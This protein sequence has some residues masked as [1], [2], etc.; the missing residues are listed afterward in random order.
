MKLSTEYLPNFALR[1]FLSFLMTSTYFFEE[2]SLLITCFYFAFFV[3]ISVASYSKTTHTKS[4]LSQ[5]A[6][7]I[8]ISIL[9]VLTFLPSSII[10][11]GIYSKKDL[12]FSIIA[13]IYFFFLVKDIL[14]LS[15][16]QSL[17]IRDYKEEKGTFRIYFLSFLMVSLIYLWAFYPGI[18]VPDSINQW[19]QIHSSM[20]WNDWH[21]I[22]HTFLIKVT[23]LIGNKPVTF[24]LFQIVCYSL[25]MAYAMDFIKDYI[26]KS[27]NIFVLCFFLVFPLLPLSSIQIIKDS[28]FTIA[29]VLLTICLLKIVGSQGEWLSSLSHRCTLSLSFLGVIFFRHN[30]WPVFIVF[31]LICLLFLRKGYFRLY[32]TAFICALFYLVI[33]GPIYNHYEVIR[34]DS[35]ES[36]GMLIQISGEIISSDGD[37]NEKEATYYYS[38]MSKENWKALYKPRDVD[39][40]KFKSRFQKKI[41][42][43]D[44]QTFILTTLS[45]AKK[46]PGLA[47]KAYIQQTEVL[48]HTNMPSENL[49]PMFRTQLKGKA[50]P[51]YFLSQ[52]QM[53]K[54][55]PDYRGLFLT[56]SR[57][58]SKTLENFFVSLFDRIFNSSIRYLFMPAVFLIIFLLSSG[59]L[60]LKGYGLYTLAFL[61]Y[62]LTLGTMFV[63]IPAPDIRYALP[64][65]FI[66]I[67][68]LCIALGIK[69]KNTKVNHKKYRTARK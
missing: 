47:V 42:Q 18:F 13:F 36:L 66:S 26:T 53:E 22:A 2:N 68:A 62:F 29:L 27:I 63:A 8:I 69:N 24:V 46:N 48:W 25:V 23:T 38:L 65:Y 49:R 35:T 64:N 67:I 43:D 3:I 58:K 4:T 54:Y 11:S 31:L 45:I 15:M 55:K 40:I 5:I 50:G 59:I 41:I 30:G 37:I 28:S 39:N 32:S 60:W 21:P 1:I 44:P 57:F 12:L 34:T 19:D 6:I 33:T 51:Y 17:S 52:D 20:P 7:N 14:N 16:S 61:P 56:D 9:A 10:N